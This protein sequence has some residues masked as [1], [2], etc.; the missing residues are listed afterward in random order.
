MFFDVFRE[1][2]PPNLLDLLEQFQVQAAF[3]DDVA[4]AVR[5]GDNP[6]AQLLRLLDGIDRDVARTGHH[7]RLAVQ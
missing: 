4:V 6:G 5:A 2:A 1:P 7:H 3:V